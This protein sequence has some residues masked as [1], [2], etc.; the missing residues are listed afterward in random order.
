MPTSARELVS[1]LAFALS[2][3]AALL[4]LSIV[5]PAG[6]DARVETRFLALVVTAVLGALALVTERSA[7]ELLAAGLLAVG[8]AWVIPSGPLRGTVVWIV[9]ASALA[10]ASFRRLRT[11]STLDSSTAFGIIL[12]TQF[13]ARP[14]LLLPLSF[15]LHRLVALFGLPLV[16]AFALA[17]LARRH[18]PATLLLIATPLFVAGPGFDT[19]ATLALVALA[20]G[21]EAGKRLPPRLSWLPP[22]ALAVL[23]FFWEP[24]TVLFL[25]LVGVAAVAASSWRRQI[26]I[27]LLALGLLWLEPT[28]RPPHVLLILLP[29]LLALAPLALARAAPVARLLSAATLLVV[30]ILVVPESAAVVAPL[31]FCALIEGHPTP[32]IR[33]ASL[34]A[35]LLA[36]G[37]LLTAGYP[38]LRSRPLLTVLE[39][40]HIAPSRFAAA[41]FLLGFFALSWLAGRS[42]RRRG[43]APAILALAA[44]ILMLL[45]L[46][47]HWP[48]EPPGP[49][50]AAPVVLSPRAPRW[51]APW[52]GP[53][54]AR[55]LIDTNAA[56]VAS[57]AA[58][59]VLARVVLSS[60]NGR[61]LTRLLRLGRDSDDWALWRP[62]LRSRLH[63]AEALPWLHWVSREQFFASRYRASWVLPSMPTEKLA[64]I[65]VVRSPHL[66]P[67]VT[68]SID[69]VGAER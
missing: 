38:W 10:L 27:S 55:L 68:F 6:G 31:A 61:P 19:A 45:A 33:L 13:L 64:Q 42:F 3:A 47:R 2:A 67:G 18:S 66:P 8:A 58:G 51:S 48:L 11:D 49:R 20:L 15:D 28:L 22:A 5:L 4:A 62:D 37:T 25:A 12:G 53:M 1:R 59:T 60:G 36:F 29:L 57:L 65:A 26:T 16:A 7:G 17:V 52:N 69:F 24:P 44:M 41:A 30:G 32:A 21:E 46:P 50:L 43:F 54:P 23:A 40:F 35:A 14:S 34:W 56:N 9:L 63:R 39:V